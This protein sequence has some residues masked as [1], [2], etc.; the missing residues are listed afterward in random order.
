MQTTSQEGVIA[1]GVD[2]SDGSRRALRWAID[3]ARRRRRVVEVVTAWPPR[4]TGDD[5][6]E[7]EATEARQQAD[8]AGRHV[9]DAV[10]RETDDPPQVSYEL[11]HGDAVEV[12][13][14]LSQRAELLVVGSHGVSSIRHAA[15][16][17][18]SEAC[19]RQAACPVVVLPNQAAA[20]TRFDQ[21]AKR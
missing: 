7:T 1:V 15:L 9:V 2:G 19:A 10:L 8:Q 16:G 3:E 21:V 13:V 4:G 5:L 20:E 17:S 14:Q 11:V 6:D 18:V 12:L